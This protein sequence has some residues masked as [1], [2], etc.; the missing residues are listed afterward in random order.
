MIGMSFYFYRS[1]FHPHTV[2]SSIRWCLLFIVG[3]N[4][5]VM[6]EPFTNIQIPR[7]SRLVAIPGTPRG[8]EHLAQ[9]GMSAMG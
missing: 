8:G 3:A 7:M 2:G 9:G 5:K 1:P 6:P 4:L